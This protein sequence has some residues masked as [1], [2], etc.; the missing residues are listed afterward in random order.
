MTPHEM[1]E[2][3]RFTATTREYIQCEFPQLD[4]D[5]TEQAIIEWGTNAIETNKRHPD[6][7]QPLKCKNWQMKAR[8]VIRIQVINKWSSI[9]IPKQGYAIDMRWQETMA[10]ARDIG[11]TKTKEGE[12]RSSDTV[13]SYR[14]RMAQW[15]K[16]PAPTAQLFDFGALKKMV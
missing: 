9:A 8:N 15:E 7:G 1:P 2:N 3:F 16:R 5:K 13:D 11:F 6:Y 14:S 4:I 10:K 12:R